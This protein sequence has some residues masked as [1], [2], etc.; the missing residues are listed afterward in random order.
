[1][2]NKER[3]AKL[4][5]FSLFAF[6]ISFCKT[7]WW[8]CPYC[9]PHYCVPKS[10]SWQFYST[11]ILT[12]NILMFIFTNY[13]RS[14]GSLHFDSNVLLSGFCVRFSF[15][16]L[17]TILLSAIPSGTN[18][19]KLISISACASYK[20]SIFRPTYDPLLSVCM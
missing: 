13:L 20:I 9:C 18:E 7:I 6:L 4:T 17:S 12:C 8:Q 19:H 11:M 16:T 5:Y 10:L 1:M 14:L 15:I 2:K 3:F